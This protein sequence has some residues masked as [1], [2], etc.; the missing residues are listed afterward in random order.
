MD[1]SKE[2][3]N[4]TSNDPKHPN[5][6]GSSPQQSSTGSVTMVARTNTPCKTVGMETSS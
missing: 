5:S 2:A 4:L 3:E 6:T 1:D